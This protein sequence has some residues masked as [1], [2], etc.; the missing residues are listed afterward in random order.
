ML[1]RFLREAGVFTGA[2]VNDSEDAS[3]VMRLVRHLVERWY[4]TYGDFFREGDPDLD[5]LVRSVFDI[6]FDGRQ[7]AG[8]WGWK[9]CETLYALPVVA[10][11]FPTA[12][13][14][15]LVRD[16]RD[17]SFSNH[18]WPRDVFWRKVYFDT[19]RMREWQDRRLDPR[20]YRQE[21]H[22]FN[23]RHWVNS[24]SVARQYGAML[25]ARY[26][27]VR[28]EALVRDFRTTARQLAR[29]LDLAVDEEFLDRF[30]TTVST[31]AVGKHREQPRRARAAAEAILEP[32]LTAF[33]YGDGVSHAPPLGW[34]HLAR[35][36]R[37]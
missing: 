13:F 35:A 21:P 34:R 3:D 28:Y 23:A 33:G 2:E 25:G 36:L 9:L 26:I 29:W 4:P 37:P 7:P 17:V 30:A 31:G 1:A 16:G 15:H 32:T 18:E 24:V 5:E 20:A 6:H 22:I 19:D 12:L 27:E 10:C 8:R 14:V 11:L